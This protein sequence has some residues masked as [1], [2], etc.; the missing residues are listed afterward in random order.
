MNYSYEEKNIL[1][2][3][4][5]GSIGKALIH[6]LLK[7]NPKTIR[8][9]DINENGLFEYTQTQKSNKI[10]TF[11][12]DIREKERVQRAINGIDIV[13]HTAALK[14]VP[15]CEYNP[16]EAIKTN[17]LGTQNLIE[18]AIDENI[19]K[20]ITISTDKAVNPINVMGATK[21]LAERLTISANLYKGSNITKF[22]CCRFGNVL[23]T[24]GSVIPVFVNQIKNQRK[25]T[26]T[27]ELMTRFMMTL[28]NATELVLEIGRISSGGEIFILKM[29]SLKIIDLAEVI[30]EKVCTKYDLN[31]KDIEV[32]Y[33]GKR[34]GEK[35]YENLIATTEYDTCYESEKMFMILPHYKEL[36]TK[37]TRVSEIPIGF[38]KINNPPS[39]S[40]KQILNKN[41]IFTLLKDI[42]V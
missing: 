19:E 5:V 3:G 18:V 13:F 38:K 29:P 33:I 25:I 40:D 8:I 10:R 31:P 16:F 14:H 21:L 23:N 17:V 4:G 28:E 12:G 20:F 37:F 24:R 30:I 22:A 15:L 1:V 32:E 2:T 39:S 34:P 26:I 27:D 9:L 6:Q 42:S 7:E 35:L 36:Y 41:E 11:I